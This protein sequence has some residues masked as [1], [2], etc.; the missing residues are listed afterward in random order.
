MKQHIEKIPIVSWPREGFHYAKIYLSPSD[1]KEQLAT[2]LR[3]AATETARNVENFSS[4]NLN[5]EK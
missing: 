1:R 5:A 3:A 4:D 2:S